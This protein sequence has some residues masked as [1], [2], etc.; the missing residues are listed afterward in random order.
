MIT[1]SPPK[2]DSDTRAAGLNVEL[3]SI[4]CPLASARIEPKPDVKNVVNYVVITIGYSRYPD[5]AVPA[6][7]VPITHK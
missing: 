3:I 7:C 4:I 5:R 1:V 2:D 6:L